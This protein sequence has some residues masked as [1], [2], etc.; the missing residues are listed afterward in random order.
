MVTWLADGGLRIG[1]LCGLHLV[2]LHLREDAACGQCRT[3]HL[4][5]CH[6]PGNPNRAEAKT[7]HP[8]RVE[9]GDGDRRA[10]QAGQPG[11]DPHL[12]RLHHHRVP[13][14]R[15]RTGCCWC[16]CTARTRGSRGRRW[17]PARMLAPRRGARRASGTVNPHA[18]RHSFTSAVLDASRRQPGDR[19]G[20]GRVG[21]GA[22]WSTRST[23]TSTCTTRRSTRRCARC[24]VSSG[25]G[26]T[27]CCR[28]AGTARDRA[29]RDRL[30]ILTALID[31]AVVRPAVPRRRDHDPGRGTR[32]TGGSAWSAAASG[33][34]RAA[35]DLCD[36]HQQ[37][38]ARERARGGQGRVPGCRAA[39][40]PRS[41]WVGG[42]A[43]P[44]LPGPAGRAHRAAAVSAAPACA[45]SAT[46]SRDGQRG[47]LRGVARRPGARSPGTGPAGWRSART[48]R[49][50][51]WACAPATRAATRRDGR[52][53]GAALPQPGGTAT[54][55]T[56]TAGP[57]R[58]RRRAAV[59]RAGAPP[60]PAVP[61]PGQVNLP[62]CAPLVRAEIQWGLFA[63]TQR[64][65]PH[66]VGHWAGS[67]PLVTTCRTRGTVLADRA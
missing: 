19:P 63:H 10:D 12:L 45:G 58:L 51:R 36:E 50:R 26:R 24:G 64:A 38:W 41:V 67:R 17:R 23:A 9:D 54:S 7:K 48:W 21:V 20:C 5:V 16:S 65:R 33:P 56:A 8:W 55:S 42:D 47:R 22:R 30:E 25:D 1:E 3:P 13:A 52:P 61:W 6:R 60:Q 34:A 4:H 2:D 66:P 59:P 27:R 44:D 35:S 32:S 40:L 46:S 53:G 14:R 28:S 57:G 49:T 29:G 62:G 15:R 31:G 37:Q 39:G 11:D 18:F 43:V